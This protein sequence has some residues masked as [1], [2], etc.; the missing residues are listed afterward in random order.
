MLGIEPRVSY[1]WGST[2]DAP[3]WT[4][5]GYFWKKVLHSQV[6]NMV[7]R[8]FTYVDLWFFFFNSFKILGL[9]E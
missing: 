8:G 5:V 4:L 9:A 1:R 2:I 6:T 3:S 7:L